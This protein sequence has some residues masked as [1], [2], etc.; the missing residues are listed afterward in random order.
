M[1]GLALS[2]PFSLHLTYT[3]SNYSIPRS[4]RSFSLEL[5]QNSGSVAQAM[6]QL[7]CIAQVQNSFASSGYSVIRNGIIE[8]ADAARLRP[9]LMTAF[10]AIMAFAPLDMGIG[11]G[12]QPHQPLAIALIGGLVF[13][14]PLLLVELPT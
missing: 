5:L 3:N 4:T 9:E 2:R 8:Y 1:K 13:A 10:V 14:L 11:T 12:T 7:F 6:Q